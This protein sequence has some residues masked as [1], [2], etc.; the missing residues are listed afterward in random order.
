MICHGDSGND[1]THSFE[2]TGDRAAIEKNLEQLINLCGSNPAE[3]EILASETLARASKLDDPALIG[4]A[5]SLLSRA[6]SLLRD[7]SESADLA[8]RAVDI[9]RPLDEKERL[10]TALNNKGN[11]DRRMGKPLY[12]IK[13]FEEALDIQISIGSRR[14]T[15][16]VHNNLGL[17]F[18]DIASYERAYL[19]FRQTVDIADEIEDQFLR[20]T[21]LSNIADVL[22][23]QGEYQS[24]R[25]YLEANLKVNREIGRRTGE[26]F[27][28]WELGR[29]TQKQGHLGDAERFLR[30]SIALRRELGS[31]QTGQCIFDL[32]DLLKEA[33]RL[34][35]A[36]EV[37]L[38]AIDLFGE[39]DNSTDLCLARAGLSILR[40]HMDRLEG[41]EKPLID[42]LALL[43]R[44]ECDPDRDLRT[45]ALKALSEYS[46]K[47]GNLPKALEYSRSYTEEREMLFEQR[48]RQNIT[49]LKLRADFQI[50]ED[51][52]VL[53]EQKTLELEE[54]NAR[55]Q[56][57]AESIKSLQG[58]LP[59][60]ARCKKIRSD[61]GYWE[62]IEQYISAHSNATFTHGFCPECIQ[63]LYPEYSNGVEDD[64]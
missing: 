7:S 10:A 4:T 46:E 2:D 47:M 28:L 38:E 50:S 25:Q 61:D 53:L 19:S 31:S 23:D 20:T 21:A 63:E 9:L 17:A 26:A 62:Q 58:M 6:V 60:C 59:I 49:R 41:A 3:A 64:I 32:A 56:R 45:Q 35:E 11:C 40:I 5:L 15:A 18:R 52:R 33:G 27:C 37:L 22:I 36:E 42:L 44:M 14:G 55:L 43:S 57:A 13:C 34:R 1:S 30:E 12:A 8:A 48:Q 51:A 54:T 29:L 39:G 16:V 24:A